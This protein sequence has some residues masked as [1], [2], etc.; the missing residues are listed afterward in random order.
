MAGLSIC[1]ASPDVWFQT[2]DSD[3]AKE[4]QAIVEAWNNPSID[5]F[6]FKSSG[7][8]G[9][10]KT[11]WF[12]RAQIIGSA[13][14]T[15]RWLGMRP[16]NR[17]LLALPLHYVAGRMIVYRCLAEGMDLWPLEPSLDPWQEALEADAVS[18]TPSMM[19]HMLNQAEGKQKFKQIRQ[20]LL[21]GEPVP[22]SLLSMLSPWQQPVVWHTYGMTETLTQV[23]ARRLCPNQTVEF[24]RVDASLEFGVSESGT[25]MVTD[26]L[27]KLSNL[28][29]KDAVALIG[30][31][32]FVWKGRKD[33][34]IN[35]GG[36][37]LY[38]EDWKSR[39]S[40]PWLKGKHWLVVGQ[41]DPSFGEVPILLVETNEVPPEQLLQELNLKLSRV[42]KLKGIKHTERFE[43]GATGKIMPPRSPEI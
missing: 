17:W 10:R 36:I 12:S 16:G 28:E 4:I 13:Q 9:K 42:M 38:P 8:T 5:R 26:H 2:Q 6:A 15:H 22:Q 37:K 27:L 21:G 1:G 39:L 33:Q 14:R 18:L 35:S 23:A 40:H 32:A 3:Q 30:P 43:R 11:L 41:E 24:K 34:V 25:L 20:V 29:T 31:G 7:T 19:L